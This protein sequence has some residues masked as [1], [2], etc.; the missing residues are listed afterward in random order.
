MD[1]IKLKLTRN[2]LRM[3]LRGLVMLGS[4]VGIGL[5]VEHT[6]LGGMLSERWIDSEIR[7][8]GLTG[9]LLFLAVGAAAI[10]ISVPRQVISFLGGY[11]FDVWLGSGLALLATVLSATFAF[12]WSRLLAR[13]LVAHR[14]SGRVERLDRFLSGNPFSMTL[15]IRLLPAGHNLTTNLIA[16]VSSVPALPFLGGSALGFIP[17]TLV[18]ALAGSGVSLDPWSRIGGGAALFV[19]SGALG[20][21]LYRKLRH[22]K[23]LDEGLDRE[24]G[25]DEPGPP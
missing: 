13:S 7:G 12:F 1:A 25:A 22:G 16:G 14:F 2:R 19:V 10:T 8:Q 15:L 9:E 21:H 20:I 5:L 17:Q 3:V 18:F 4:L 11:A 23:S 6:D 24:I